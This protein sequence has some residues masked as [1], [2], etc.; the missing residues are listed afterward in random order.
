MFFLDYW[1]ILEKQKKKIGAHS[2][3]TPGVIFVVRIYQIYQIYLQN[4]CR[5]TCRKRN[6]AVKSGIFTLKIRNFSR[7]SFFLVENHILGELGPPYRGNNPIQKSPIFK[8]IYIFEKKKSIYHFFWDFGPIF[9]K[10]TNFQGLP[11]V[12]KNSK[13]TKITENP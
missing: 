11:R 12:R 5:N 2:I 9:W 13:M 4:T 8:Y 10:G 6:L 1:K 3:L 7:V